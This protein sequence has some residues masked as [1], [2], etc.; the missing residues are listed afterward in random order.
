MPSLEEKIADW[1]RQMAAGG[2]K[3]PA[4]LDELEGHLREDVARQVRSGLAEERAFELAAQRMGKCDLLKAEFAKLGAMKEGRAGKVIAI[5]CCL[6]AA[7]YSMLL[8]PHLFTIRELSLAQRTLGLSAVALTFFSLV[9]WRF[10][11]RYL[12]IIRSRRARTMAVMACGLAGVAWLLIF[13]NLLPNVIVPHAMHEGTS[14]E[15]IRGSVLIGLRQATPDGFTAVFTIGISL[16][17][18]MTLAAMLGAVAYG[19]EAAVKRGTKE[20]VYV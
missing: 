11:Y 17:W 18:A 16:L 2:I 8:A 20:N 15:S 9:S 13:A 6:F 10:S 3:T 19:L 5:A 14:A 7:L 4:V 1:R 12:P